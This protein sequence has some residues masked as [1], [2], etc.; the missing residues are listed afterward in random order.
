MFPGGTPAVRLAAITETAFSEEAL[1][2][3]GMSASKEAELLV[4]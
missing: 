3:N 2:E 4:Q 1:S